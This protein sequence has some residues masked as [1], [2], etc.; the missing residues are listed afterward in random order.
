MTTNPILTSSD[1]AFQN[2]ME[3][4]DLLWV[5][6]L[7]R[8]PGSTIP[9]PS[10]VIQASDAP[11][12]NAFKAVETFAAGLEAPV[13]PGAANSTG[14][15]GVSGSKSAQSSGAPQSNETS[16][17][18]KATSNTPAPRPTP[19]STSSTA[20]GGAASQPTGLMMVAGAAIA[21]VVGVAAML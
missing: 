19:T 8:P 5:N 3:Q 9:L 13:G 1:A 11:I 21:G 12:S 15:A 14:P 4:E 17:T 6:E 16:I 18:S 20:T 7:A 2:K 10:W